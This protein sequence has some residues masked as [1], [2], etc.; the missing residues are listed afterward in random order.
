MDSQKRDKYFFEIFVFSFF[1]YHGAVSGKKA[2]NLR[3]V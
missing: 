1:V 2:K 3:K